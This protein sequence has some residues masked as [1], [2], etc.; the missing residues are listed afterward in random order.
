MNLAGAWKIQALQDELKLVAL[1]SSEP[2]NKVRLQA[3]RGLAAF[4]DTQTL[5]AI[6]LDPNQ[7]NELIASTIKLLA[8]VNTQMAA[9]LTIQFLRQLSPKEIKQHYSIIEVFINRKNGVAELV[10]EFRDLD[11]NAESKQA[12][13]TLLNKSGQKAQP[14]SDAIGA[15]R[16]RKIK[17]EFSE[18]ELNAL[19]KDV[20]KTGNA[21]RGETVYRRD[22]LSC[23]KCHAIGGSGGIVGPDLISL[24]TSSPMDYIIDSLVN[25]N[26]KIKEGYHTT[27]I[28]TDDGRLFS[29]KLISQSDSQVTL[30]DAEN[31]E[32]VFSDE[33]IEEQK[34]SNH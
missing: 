4:G 27:T 7:P 17:M 3:I 22:N 34:I 19:I 9:K 21:S 18:A 1:G 13:V 30:R 8:G 10:K 26:A 33:E 2:S 14:L 23:I 28:L 12:L 6:A 24:G 20:Q 25:P 31:K 11:L 16:N 5:E 15:M 29:G 32:L